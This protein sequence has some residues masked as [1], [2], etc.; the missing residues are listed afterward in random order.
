MFADIDHQYRT[1]ASRAGWF[2]RAGHGVVRVDGPDRLTFLHALLTNDTMSLA[3]GRGVAAAYLTPQ[4]RMLADVEV[5]NR[6][7]HVLV[8]VAPAAAAALASRLDGIIFAEQV[9]VTDTSRDWTE[10]VVTGATAAA[11]AAEAS[12]AET[13][14]LDPLGELEHVAI[15]GGFVVRGGESPLPLFRLMVA[16]GARARIEQ[17]LQALDVPELAPELVTALRI[18][19]GRPRWAV[20][21]FEDTIPLEAGLLERAISTSK[22]C[23]VGQEVIIRVLHRGGG[24][25][26]RRLVQL[27]L[28]AGGTDVPAAGTPI[29]YNAEVAGRITSAAWSPARHAVL[30]LGYV[31]RDAAT[32]GT[33]VGVGGAGTPAEIVG[34]AR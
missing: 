25:V 5:L 12:G 34:F 17:R 13:D 18:E 19:A 30:A 8:L 33:I 15:E 29:A 28:P 2:G 4:G 32:V 3:E 23:Y 26:A 20:D 16:P 21:L 27:A 31:H 1:I 14:A 10:T 11:V 6:G 24:R 9:S 7:D 22:G